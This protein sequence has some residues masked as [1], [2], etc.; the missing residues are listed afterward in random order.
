MFKIIL[1]SLLSTVGL[2]GAE[3]KAKPTDPITDKMRLEFVT[4]QRD[5]VIMQKEIGNEPLAK[6]DKA[7]KALQV[8]YD[9]ADGACKKQNKDTAFDGEKC[10]ALPKPLAEAKPAEKK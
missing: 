1:L 3:D 10:V 4:A 6:L 8:A 5:V 9:T 7:I 2:M